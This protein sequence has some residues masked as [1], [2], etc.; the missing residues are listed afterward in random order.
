MKLDL[1]MMAGDY[2][3]YA[4]EI[5]SGSKRNDLNQTYSK[6]GIQDACR[7]SMYNEGNIATSFHKLED[8]PRNSVPFHSE[9]LPKPFQSNIR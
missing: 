6:L 1:G 3:A 5:T 8:I 4:R 2:T 9:T 7:A